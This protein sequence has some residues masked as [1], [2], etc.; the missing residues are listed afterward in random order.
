MLLLQTSKFLTPSA[1]GER[2]TVRLRDTE[3]S[4]IVFPAQKVTSLALAACLHCLPVHENPNP[5]RRH[6]TL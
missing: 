5:P 3:N 4:C 6:C 1:V 2:E